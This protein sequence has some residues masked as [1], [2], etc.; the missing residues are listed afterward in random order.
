MREVEA[1]NNIVVSVLSKI[2]KRVIK[3]I[4]CGSP[5]K[6]A[7]TERDAKWKI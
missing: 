1:T 5:I 7:I 6:L 2:I 4:V 3:G